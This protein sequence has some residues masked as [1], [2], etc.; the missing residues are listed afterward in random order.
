MS[1]CV[2]AFGASCVARYPDFEGERE[3]EEEGDG[4]EAWEGKG[5][6]LR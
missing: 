5:E 6:G 4:D 2:V 3:R 1:V